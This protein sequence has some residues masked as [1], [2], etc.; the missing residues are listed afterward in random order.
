MMLA[1]AINQ[2]DCGDE[3]QTIAAKDSHVLI[4]MVRRTTVFKTPKRNQQMLAPTS[5]LQDPQNDMFS[6]I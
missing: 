2:E 6:N 4:E 3:H 5:I 1:C